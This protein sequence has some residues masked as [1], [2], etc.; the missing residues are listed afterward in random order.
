MARQARI[1]F[2]HES[3]RT[4]GIDWPRAAESL[5]AIGIRACVGFDVD[6]LYYEHIDKAAEH[7]LD[8]FTVCLPSA[9]INPIEQAD[10]YFEL[11]EVASRPQC[12][13]IEPQ[14]R[15]GPM[16]SEYQARKNF[17][18][19]AERNQFERSAWYY[20][21]YASTQRLGF[22]QWIK[23]LFVYWAEYPYDIFP[24]FYSKFER[25]LERNPWKIPKWAGRAGITPGIH[26]L[27]EKGDGRYYFTNEYTGDPNFPRG[28]KNCTLGL[29]LVDVQELKS[30]WGG[31]EGPPPIEQ[32][33]DWLEQRVGILSGFHGLK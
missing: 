13:D 4:G 14:W 3:Y 11:P 24:L 25:Y 8:F 20:S 7:E 26:Q 30:Q 16:V 10:F 29:S 5:D 27:S 32:R 1:T 28:M 21:N 9:S 18:R 17:E 2:I 6:D 33:V 23:D 22:P 31:G 15:G 12:L 19:L